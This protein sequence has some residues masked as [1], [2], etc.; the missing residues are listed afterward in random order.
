LEIWRT[1]AMP[2]VI[3]GRTGF[4][5]LRALGVIGGQDRPSTVQK[6]TDVLYRTGTERR[7]PRLA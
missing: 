5:P 6:L 4:F 3:P 7:T 2:V 1:M